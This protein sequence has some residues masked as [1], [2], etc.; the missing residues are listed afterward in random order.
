VNAT[1]DAEWRARFE[2]FA[3]KHADEAGVSGWSACGLRR[4]SRTFDRLLDELQ[5]PADARVLDVGCGAG[6][7][8]R[9]LAARGHRAV[10]VD[11]SLP[12][13]GRALD[14]DGNA[15][16]R[17]LAGDAYTL[18]FPGAM[19]DLVVSIGVLQAL[20]TPERVLGEL[21][22]VAKPGGVLV[23]EALNGS[24]ATARAQRWVEHLQGRPPRVRMYTPAAVQR[25]LARLGLRVERRVP[26]FLPPRNAPRLERLLDTGALASAMTAAPAVTN[27]TAHTFLFVARAPR[28]S[29]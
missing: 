22:R 16:G 27:L 21:A 24:A 5:L 26:I 13:L 8:V 15:H 28:V 7:Y 25:W 12:T 1:F 2:R 17:Y 14:A 3:T 18:P 23:L 9:L 19:F 10:G 6:T 20:A 11:Y 4:R 29:G